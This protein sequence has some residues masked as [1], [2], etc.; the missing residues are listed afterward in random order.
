MRFGKCFYVEMRKTGTRDVSLTVKKH[1]GFSTI[2]SIFRLSI[3]QNEFI[4]VKTVQR[5][6]NEIVHP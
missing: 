3:N 4:A 1:P 6:N 2:I 5:P